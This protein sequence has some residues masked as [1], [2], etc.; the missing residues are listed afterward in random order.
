VSTAGFIK[1]KEKATSSLFKIP[2]TTTMA[3][4]SV[5][6]SSKSDPPLSNGRY[7]ARR[8]P[9]PPWDIDLDLN[10]DDNEVPAVARQPAPPP[11]EMEEDS[12]ADIPAIPMKKSSH[13]PREPSPDWNLDDLDSDESDD[14]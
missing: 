6:S 4:N 10:P 2:G 7:Q 12:D 8:S 3:S 14:D 9:S 5:A 11:W 1:G 13:A